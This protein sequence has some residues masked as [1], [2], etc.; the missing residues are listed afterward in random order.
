MGGQKS[1]SLEQLRQSQPSHRGSPTSVADVAE[2]PNVRIGRDEHAHEDRSFGA[3]P[4][5]GSGPRAPPAMK[6]VSAH[7]AS[8]H[9]IT[10]TDTV[11]A[12][13]G[14]LGDLD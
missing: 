4:F 13:T 3:G 7:V 6:R 1:S 8:T 12:R 10:P 11:P 14:G 5:K 9:H 2:P